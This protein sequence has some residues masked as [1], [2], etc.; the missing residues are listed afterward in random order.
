MSGAQMNGDERRVLRG[1]GVSSGVASGRVRLMHEP[2]GVDEGEPACADPQ[3]DMI[4]VRAAMA[5]VASSLRERSLQAADDTTRAMLAANARLA[6]DRGLDKAIMKHLSAGDGVTHAVANAVGEYIER[7]GK[8]G[9]MMAERITDLDDIRSRLI[10]ELREL[11]SAGPQCDAVSD[12]I[13][14][15]PVILVARDL[16]PA[17]AAALDPAAVRGLVLEEGGATGHTAILA[18]ERGIPAVVGV[19][20]VMEAADDDTRIVLN[21]GTGEVIINPDAA[22][23]YRAAG[24]A[25]RRKALLHDSASGA[26]DGTAAGAAAGDAFAMTADGCRILLNANVGTPA[27]AEE[28]ARAGVDGIGLLRS[29]FLFLNR[30]QAPTEAEQAEAYT[31]AVQ[32]FDGRPVVVRTFDAGADKPLAFARIGGNETLAVTNPALGVRGIRLGMLREDLLDTQLAAL[33]NAYRASGHSISG[34]SLKVMAPMATTVQETKWFVD[35]AHAAGLPHAGIMIETPAAAVQAASLLAVADFASIGTN[36]LAQYTMAADRLDGS[37][38]GLLDPWQP[39]L[40][41]MMRMAVEGGLMAGKPVGVCGEAA[42]DPLLA[43]VFVGF[44]IRSLS[45]A[46]RKAAA[47]RSALRLHSLADCRRMAQAALDARSAMEA[48]QSALSLADSRL[49]DV[50]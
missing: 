27:E 35:K 13:C 19:H 37:L 23:L 36:D 44:G 29:E 48:R 12:A 1:I 20:G 9:G 18:A 42:G 33:A 45:M 41:R 22:D 11:P 10:A 16:S 49:R 32:A 43:L 8:A 6:E 14:D 47:V 39:A 25:A 24:R 2:P 5:A 30:S 4:R 15:I 26:A 50:L 34:H 3:L 21:G 46:W 7:F 31:R 38:S 17:D 40:L 28:A